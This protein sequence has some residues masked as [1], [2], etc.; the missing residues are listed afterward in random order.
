MWNKRDET[1]DTS[2]APSATP[3][4]TSEPRSG[5]TSASSGGRALIGESVRV[6]GT[7]SGSEDLLIEGEVEGTVKLQGNSVTVGRS[8]RVKADIHGRVLVVEGNVQGDLVAGEQAVVR[9]SGEV[10]GNITSPRVSLEDGAK[11]KGSIDMEPKRPSAPA[12]ESSS[13][14]SAA[15][16]GSAS[17]AGKGDGGGSDGKAASSSGGGSGAAA[18]GSGPDGGSSSASRSAGSGSSGGSGG[19][20]SSG[21]SGAGKDA[22]G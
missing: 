20:S 6:E 11:F 2:T 18:S 4:P 21:G 19:S 5:A 8:G 12:K 3:R 13:S 22:T 16:G 14:T 10:R 9:A 17:G 7:I 15:S 1:P